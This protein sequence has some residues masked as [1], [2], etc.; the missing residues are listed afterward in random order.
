MDEQQKII[1]KKNHFFETYISK[2]LKQIAPKNGITSNAKQQL[3]SFLCILLK[4]IAFTVSELTIIAKKKTISNKEIENTLK[5][6]LFGELLNC[7][8]KEGRKASEM[9]ISQDNIKGS[10]Q[11][12][13]NI[14]FSPSIIEKFLRNSK[15]MVSNLSPVYL[16]AVLEFIT[17]EILDISISICKQHKRIRLTIRD[18]ELAVRNDIELNVLFKKLNISFLGGGVVPFIHSSL[19]NKKKITS[20]KDTH[21]YRYG[22]IALKNIKKQQKNSDSLILAKSQFEKL[23]RH[24]LKNNL[25]DDTNIKICKGVFIVLQYFIEQF[26]INI[27]YNA[28]YL[29]I[30]AGRVKLLPIDIQ[31]YN[32]FLIHNSFNIFSKN[33]Y[34]NSENMTLLSIEDNMNYED[35]INDE[36]MNNEG[37]IYEDDVI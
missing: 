1:K 9:Y 29:T 19:L 27:L 28:N 20:K 37:D 3:N 34:I 18:L 7:C 23:V 35:G 26:I 36:D 12:R 13:A 33:P 16:A 22:T 11:N 6:I 24:L 30:H 2:V 25:E 32:S 8:I 21:K 10:R 31:L 4:K 14:I 17:Y 5:I 15:L